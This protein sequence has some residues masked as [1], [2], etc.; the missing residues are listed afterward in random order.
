ML[1][2]K[3]QSQV[4][5]AA[6]LTPPALK[7]ATKTSYLLCYPVFLQLNKFPSGLN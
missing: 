6:A 7:S 4:R 2:D 5:K 1:T 3:Q